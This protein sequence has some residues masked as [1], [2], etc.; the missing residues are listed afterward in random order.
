MKNHDVTGKLKTHC[1]DYF[2]KNAI[3]SAGK[4]EQAEKSYNPIP[5]VEKYLKEIGLQVETNLSVSYSPDIEIGCM[6]MNIFRR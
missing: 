6:K 3:G 1:E 4:I 2:F 5:Q